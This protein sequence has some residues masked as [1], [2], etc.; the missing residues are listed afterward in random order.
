MLTTYKFW[1]IHRDDD[2]FITEASVRFWEGLENTENDEDTEGNLV[3]V[4]RFRFQHA[5][6]LTEAE[7]AH[8]G[9]KFEKESSGKDVSLYH[10]EDFGAIKTD[11]ELRLFMNKELDKDSTRD[12]VA[13]QNELIDINK[14]K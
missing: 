12:A 14:V 13:A 8:T 5:T 4:K 11:D 2:G 7:L 1:K 10:P 3:P 9:N 6:R